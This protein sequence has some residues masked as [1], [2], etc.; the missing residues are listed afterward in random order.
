MPRLDHLLSR[1]VSP[2][3]L[4]GHRILVMTAKNPG[5]TPE[6]AAV[7]LRS[8]Q[9]VKSHLASIS[10]LEVLWRIN[11][12]M[13]EQLGTDNEMRQAAS[14]ELAAVVDRVDAVITTPS[15]AVLE[16]MLMDRPVAALDY[17]NVP[18]FVPA[19][20]TISAREHLPAAVAGLLQPSARQLAFQRDCLADCLACEGA[21]APRVAALMERM[22]ALSR[23][24]PRGDTGFP[25]NLL[26]ASMD[27]S[28]GTSALADLYPQHPTFAIR[29]V[30]ELQV[31]LARLQKDYD[32]L[33]QAIEHQ[34]LRAGI[35]QFGRYLAEYLRSRTPT[36][37]GSNGTSNHV[38]KA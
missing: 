31:R 12:S 30:A 36:R 26:G 8:L 33:R 37:R 16:C 14:E 5:F 11:K 28:E 23:H 15:T 10:G 32:Q 21:A 29:D 4:P 19:A 24:S 1:R 18:R 17:H 3:H 22:V 34:G 27:C 9:D 6:Q 2:R 38:K 35:R 7:T 20:W 13:A 25:P